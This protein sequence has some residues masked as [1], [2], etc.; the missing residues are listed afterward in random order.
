MLME[1]SP[2]VSSTVSVGVATEAWQRDGYFDLR[3]RVFCEETGLFDEADADARDFRAI[4]IAA[5]DWQMGMPGSVVGTVR[6]DH[7]GDDLWFGGR[8]AVD[9]AYRRHGNL[10]AQ[11][12]RCAVTTAHAWGATRFHAHVLGS[13]VRLFR[14]LR[15]IVLSDCTIQGQPHCLMEADLSQY[16]PDP[17]A[18]PWHPDTGLQIPLSQRWA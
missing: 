15:W 7:H 4:P 13:N 16:P 14:W 11:L 17:A 8:L 9:P 2:H 3:R 5:W 6:I 18:P 12:I 10:G 1:V